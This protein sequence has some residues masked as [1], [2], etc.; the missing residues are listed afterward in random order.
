MGP[1]ALAHFRVY[2]DRET[3]L[4]LLAPLAQHLGDAGLGSVSEIFDGAAPHVPR[5][6]P[7]QAWSVAEVLRAWVQ[8]TGTKP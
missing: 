3:A 1:F 6:C 7:Q 2:Q 8:I 5:G 4:A